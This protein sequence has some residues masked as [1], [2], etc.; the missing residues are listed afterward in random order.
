[1]EKE[2]WPT[3]LI[4]TRE[5]TPLRFDKRFPVERT[6]LPVGDYGVSHFSDWTNPAFII[7]RKSLDDLCHSFGKDRLRFFKECEGLRRFRFAAL[8]IEAHKDQVALGSYRSLISPAAVLAT[9]DVLAVR[10]G[11]HVIW[12][13]DA[14]GAAVQVESLARQFC[15]GVLKD[16]ARLGVAV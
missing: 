11:L 3:L 7:E 4:D 13:G 8:V 6:T 2:I 5:Q 16:A 10:Y 1:M 9:L 12:A 14:E 15:R